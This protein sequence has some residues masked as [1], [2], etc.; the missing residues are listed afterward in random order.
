MAKQ[1][2]HSLPLTI[3]HTRLAHD[4]RHFASHNA[5]T[6]LNFLR[7]GVCNKRGDDKMP[8]KIRTGG[9]DYSASQSTVCPNVFIVIDISNVGERSFLM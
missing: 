8:Q 9:G 5:D 4:L 7:G 2:L 3:W 1:S 6:K